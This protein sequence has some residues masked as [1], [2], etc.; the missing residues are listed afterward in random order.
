MCEPMHKLLLYSSV[1]R[2]RT[3][4]RPQASKAG[5]HPQSEITKIKML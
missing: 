1:L 5:V 2:G 3:G 4:R